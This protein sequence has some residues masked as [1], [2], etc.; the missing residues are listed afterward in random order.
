MLYSPGIVSNTCWQP[1]TKVQSPPR[2][3]TTIAPQV[4][5]RRHRHVDIGH[6]DDRAVGRR[7]TAAADA[8]FDGRARACRRGVAQGPA[9]A[10]EQCDAIMRWAGC[11]SVA[12]KGSECRR[13]RCATT[14]R[15]SADW[16]WR[17]AGNHGNAVALEEICV[18][19][20]RQRGRGSKDGGRIGSRGN[21]I[22]GGFCSRSF[23]TRPG[24]VTPSVPQRMQS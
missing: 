19:K 18:E 20:N 21:Q 13:W 2:S 23:M 15:T 12:I 14:R 9:A 10:H 7:P 5:G 6:I 3:T 16:N 24:R 8:V 1:K 22:R 17:R 4:L 11:D